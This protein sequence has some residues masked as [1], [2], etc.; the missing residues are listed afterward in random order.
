MADPILAT[1][2]LNKSFGALVVSRD[3]DLE[4]RAGEIHALIGPNGAGK[5]TLVKQI[6]GELKP[7]SGKVYLEGRDVSD[8]RVHQRS[9]LGIGRSFQISSVIPE[10]SSL[11]NVLLATQA[12]TG[13]SLRF[14]S[15]AMNNRAAIG[16]AD[17][18]LSSVGLE[19]RGDLIAAELS[20]GE[21]RRLEIAMVMALQPKI[22]LLDEPMAGLG[23]EGVA[24]L[25]E[26]LV[27]L[28]SRAPVL[29]IEHDMDAVFSLADRIS[30]LVYG[31]IIATG[32][33]AEVRSD[34]AVQS[35]YLGQAEDKLE[36][37]RG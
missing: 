12:K 36:S 18:L 23:P 32:S 21:R 27:R 29:L 13:G 11:Q 28:R 24:E 10:M 20:H 35:A 14:F 16:L 3:V 26:L 22:Y 34:P 8:L 4:L 33:V 25:G 5:S 6:T 1:E 7:D 30:V 17:E 9:L 2:K 15:N 19:R 31:E 37:R